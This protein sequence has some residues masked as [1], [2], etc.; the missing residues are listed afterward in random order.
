MQ[1]RSRWASLLRQGAQFPGLSPV[2]LFG[3]AFTGVGACR[4]AAGRLR[5]PLGLQKEIRSHNKPWH[6]L[7]F[8]FLLQSSP[9]LSSSSCWPLTRPGGTRSCKACLLI[10]ISTQ[11]D[12]FFVK[13][14]RIGLFQ[15]W[16]SQIRTLL[17]IWISKSV[18]VILLAL[19]VCGLSWQQSW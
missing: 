13:D 4:M 3:F 6:G 5:N 2:H 1:K 18:E 7:P 16:L 10:A 14:D 12:F 17:F 9:R 8:C 15:P 19:C 11:W